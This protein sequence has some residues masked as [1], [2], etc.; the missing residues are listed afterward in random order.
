MNFNRLRIGISEGSLCKWN[1]IAV[2]LPRLATEGLGRIA[3]DH[4]RRPGDYPPGPV[5]FARKEAL[6]SP[7]TYG[8]CAP[9]D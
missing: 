6:I 1:Y 4:R 8:L 2:P 9:A 3:L 5:Y 7:Q